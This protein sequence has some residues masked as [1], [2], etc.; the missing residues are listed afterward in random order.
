MAA[1]HWASNGGGVVAL[2]VKVR[3][4]DQEVVGFESLPTVFSLFKLDKTAQSVVFQTSTSHSVQIRGNY[5]I[6]TDLRLWERRVIMNGN[7][8]VV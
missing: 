7:V 6:M 1:H 4:C 3:T 8:M 2:S 5:E